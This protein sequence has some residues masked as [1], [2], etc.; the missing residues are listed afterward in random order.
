MNMT[1]LA[2]DDEPLALDIIESYASRVDWLQLR[3]RCLTAMEAI[4]ILREESVDI[5]FLDIQLPDL[6]GFELLASLPHPPRVIFTTAYEQFAAQ[7]YNVDAVDYLVKPFSFE[8]FLR[9]VQKA[10]DAIVHDIHAP[11]ADATVFVHTDEG[12]VRIDAQDILYVQ[13]MN[14]YAVVRTHARKFTVRESLKDIERRLARYGFLRVHKSWIV[15]VNSIVLVDH[16]V[17]R[18]GD[19]VIPVGKTYRDSLRTVID[20]R[21][22]G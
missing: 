20:R 17:L 2:V 8:R 1:C 10:A 7:S 12:D 11:V 3:G 4:A 5:L 6:N 19:A 13:G 21:R 22:I 9:A 18:V 14:E 15:A 16:N